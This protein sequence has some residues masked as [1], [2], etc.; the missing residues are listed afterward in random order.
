M[1]STIGVV[2][3]VLS[4]R[5]DNLARE[6]SKATSAVEDFKRG[7]ERVSTVI[8][9]FIGAEIVGKAVEVIKDLHEQSV[10]M[11]EQGMQFQE[12]L[13][14]QAENLGISTRAMA[15]FTVVEARADMATGALSASLAK[16]QQFIQGASKY[17]SEADV[18]LRR[19]GINFLEIA[20]LSADEQYQRIAEAISQVAT[21]SERTALAMSIFGRQGKALVET[22]SEGRAAFDDAAE[23]AEKYGL[24]LGVLDA[25][26]LQFVEGE[27]KNTK[28]ISDGLNTQVAA[29][30]SLDSLSKTYMERVAAERAAARAKIGK[31]E[32]SFWTRNLADIKDTF[33]AFGGDQSSPYGRALREARNDMAK[34]VATA[35]QVEAAN[36]AAAAAAEKTA[37]AQRQEAAAFKLAEE[38]AAAYAKVQAA[39]DKADDERRMKAASNQTAYF[40]MLDQS[41]AVADAKEARRIQDQTKKYADAAREREEIWHKE[42][43]ARENALQ[44]DP[45][46]R[47]E[48]FATASDDP[49]V[50]HEA[51]VLDAIQATRTRAQQVEDAKAA[52]EQYKAINTPG[53]D[54]RVLREQEVQRLILKTQADAAAAESQQQRQRNETMAQGYADFFG[55]LA[56]ITAA[57]SD[58]NIATFYAIK[59]LMMAQAEINSWMAY[60]NVMGNI[61]LGLTVGPIMQQV[62]AYTALAAGQ[63]AV[64][65]IAAQQPA[66]RANGGPVSRGGIYEV[67]ERGPEVLSIGDKSFLMMGNKDGR[68]QPAG[69]G[70]SAPQVI[71]NVH[72]APGTAARVEHSGTADAPR[73]DVI[74]ERVD[75]AVASGIRSG[76]GATA[77]AIQATYGVN[78]ARGAT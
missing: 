74:I 78:R 1:G 34:A 49:R 33:A 35:E 53:S 71:V 72:S 68:V 76:A 26:R 62:M 43:A 7:F 30:N 65:K 39:L 66:A 9:A 77:R 2:Q 36:V 45:K 57:A 40:L 25:A 31:D 59:S 42:Q 17:G 32:I 18:T 47:A 14:R 60:S 51:L 23:A 50:K 64:Y 41:M 29:A 70:R 5:D 3:V 21:A 15:A 48:F 8:H 58:N 67:N 63:I 38:S 27:A 56:E 22:L 16:M 6:M 13:T 12:A 75:Q 37:D 52:Q 19:L 10:R 44:Y 69:P 54:I 61:Q 4:A 55:N 11:T 20:A 24:S 28:L 73:L 46:A